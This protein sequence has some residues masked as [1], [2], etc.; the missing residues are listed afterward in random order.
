MDCATHQGDRC[1]GLKYIDRVFPDAK[2]D[3]TGNSVRFIFILEQMGD[4]DPLNDLA[5]IAKVG[6]SVLCRLCHNDLVTLAGYHH[7]P[8]T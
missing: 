7:L 8:F 5:V 4:H 2:A 6:H 3:G 1:L